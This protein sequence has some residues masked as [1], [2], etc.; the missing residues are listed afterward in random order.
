MSAKTVKTALEMLVLKHSLPF[1]SSPLFPGGLVKRVMVLAEKNGRPLIASINVINQ[2]NLHC[3][4]C[5]WSKVERKQQRD[6]MTVV[7][8]DQLVKELWT[9]GVRQFLFLGGEPMER[10]EE[11]AQ[12]VK[13]VATLGGISG[14]ITN[15]TYGIPPKGEWPKT[16]YMISCDGDRAGMDKVRG[17]DPEH[18]NASVFELVKQAA[19]GRSDVVLSMTL[20]SLNAERI[21]PF[22]RE[23]VTWGIGGVAFAFATP[24]V[25]E[26][27]GFYLSAE[28]KEEAVQQ[29][30]RL[31]Q[32]FGDFIFM[33]RR[34]I[35]L[36]R[37]SEVAK[38]SPKCPTFAAVSIRAD[39]K[40]LERCIFGPQG[41]CSQCG[42]NVTTTVVALQEG[43]KETARMV[44]LPARRAG[45]V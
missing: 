23:T 5:Y 1:L 6:E 16:H 22:V 12:W 15:A 26:Q 17:R 30:L 25:G 21:E 42:C 8:G 34:A 32:E 24:N 43:D 7:Q 36:L 2:C 40:P 39:G 11:L 4:G 3:A 13:T 27:Q 9:R 14:V 10:R 38:W 19:T 29:L 37:P 31:K 33:S 35:E 20:S 41:D 44:L 28:K 45:I 18:G